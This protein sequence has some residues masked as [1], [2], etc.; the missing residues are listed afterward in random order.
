M[1][2][3]AYS[4]PMDFVKRYIKSGRFGEFVRKFL[5]SEYQ[6]RKDKAE[7]DKEWK[8]WVAYVHSYSE[9]PFGAWKQKVGQTNNGDT[10][11]AGDYS[12]DDNGIMSI[13]NNL[14]PEDGGE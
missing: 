6:R 11:Q 2:Y 3:R 8:L 7:E 14:F 13:I 5:E 12:L 1:L 10:T 4:N 9:E